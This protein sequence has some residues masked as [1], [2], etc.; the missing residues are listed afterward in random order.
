MQSSTV[1]LLRFPFSFFLMPVYWFAL[2]QVVHIDWQGAIITFF[3]LHFLL[4]PASNGYNSFMD[5]DETPVGGL[6]NPPLPT[7]Q[8]FQVTVIM[9]AAAIALS[10]LID[11]FFTGL[12][13]LYI[14]ASR[15]YSY[16]GIR[17]K[18]FPI[19][20]YL[21]VV[22]FQGA[23]TFLMVYHASQANKS[24]HIPVD[25]WKAMIASS[26][27]VGGFYP[28]T[29]VYQHEADRKDGVTTISML[30]GIRGTFIYAGVLYLLAFVQ[31]AAYFLLSFETAEFLVLATAMVPVLVY[32]FAWAVQVWK[33][34]AAADFKHTMQMN[35]LASCCTNLAFIAILLM[36]Q[37]E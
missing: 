11:P 23:V 4:Y 17:L 36:R 28:L 6:K 29:Q 21:T 13:I 24:I 2:S 34:P 25:I 14:A 19:A 32:F 10:L 27:L 8:L 35:I 20:G 1:K 26:L 16:R 18:K 30:L 31:L 12:L 22:I 3:I 37:K 9:D 7:R 33:K 15:A 5:R